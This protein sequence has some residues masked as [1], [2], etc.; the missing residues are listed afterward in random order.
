MFCETLREHSMK[1]INFEKMKII[2]L[3]NEQQQLHKSQNCQISKN[4]NKKCSNIK[5]LLIKIR[6]NLNTIFITLVNKEMLHSAVI[7]NIVYPK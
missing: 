1:V 7:Q 5:T 4:K 6:V 2:K 3:T